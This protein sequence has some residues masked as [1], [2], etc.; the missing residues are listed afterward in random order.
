MIHEMQP[1]LTW[2]MV[3]AVNLLLCLF[4]LE[5][6]TH[7]REAKIR[8]RVLTELEV[9]LLRRKRRRYAPPLLDRFLTRAEQKRRRAEFRA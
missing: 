2:L 7:R 5:F 1:A 8:Q 4:L 3:V 6:T 9:E